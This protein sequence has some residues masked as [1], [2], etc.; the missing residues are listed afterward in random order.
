MPKART[1]A[2]AV[3]S[4]AG[5]V[6][7]LYVYGDDLDQVDFADATV[8]PR[9]AGAA[10][11]YVLSAA[12]GGAAWRLILRSLG[13]SPSL[14]GPVRH[15]MLSQVGK[16]VPGNVAHYAGR[17]ALDIRSGVAAP[18][19]AAGLV[20]ETAATVLSGGSI[21]ILGWW[22]LP[23]L[24]DRVSDAVPANSG[25]LW[26]SLAVLGV[27]AAM[28]VS[29]SLFRRWRRFD[30]PPRIELGELLR[31][32]PI[33]I[34]AF[35]LLGLSLQLIVGLTSTDPG[36]SPLLSIS[37]FAVAWI[38]GFATPGAPGGLGIRETVL[39]LGLAPIIG[40]PAALS[41]AL[42]HRAANVIGDVVSFGIGMLLPTTDRADG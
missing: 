15:L 34:A 28:A 8:W 6:A 5:M 32:F 40:G 13:Q 10:A 16:Y 27:L 30:N 35:I 24:R 11:I 14:W 12:L 9:L 23:D 39:T 25:L 38:L 4:V 1:V 29:A 22:L 41:A 7:I 19:V 26:L 18:A 17:A 37:V 31:A 3:L 42:I 33:Y 36:V 20:I 21:A 2:G